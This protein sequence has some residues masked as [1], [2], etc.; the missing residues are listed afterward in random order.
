M[1]SPF[2]T[3]WLQLKYP[4]EDLE[5]LNK[6]IL[7]ERLTKFLQECKAIAKTLYA[8]NSD[9]ILKE[10]E[11]VSLVFY[12]QIHALAS[13]TMNLKFSILLSAPLRA[14]LNI[15][16]SLYGKHVCEFVNTKLKI[17][18]NPKIS[19]EDLCLVTI[20]WGTLAAMYNCKRG[21]YPLL[22][23]GN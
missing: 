21:Y 7:P 12:L 9:W 17:V 18:F 19:C 6:E 8:V 11:T 1:F 16:S 4:S 5:R 22:P 20:V 15:S 13:R 2:N 23:F 14:V 10:L 3:E